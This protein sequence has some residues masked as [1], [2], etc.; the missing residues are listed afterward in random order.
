M[1]AGSLRGTDTSSRLFGLTQIRAQGQHSQGVGYTCTR[2]HAHIQ[3]ERGRERERDAHT[4]ARAHTHRHTRNLSHTHTTHTHI[5]GDLQFDTYPYT[6][7]CMY[8]CVKV[9]ANVHV[10]VAHTHIFTYVH[11]GGDLE[12]VCVTHTHIYIRTCRGRSRV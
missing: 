10:C 7:T 1:L 4:R 12:T 5:V 2:A 3:R 8:V 9:Y 6:Q 11:V